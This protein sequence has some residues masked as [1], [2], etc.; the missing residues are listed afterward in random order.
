MELV[1]GHPEGI[2]L[3]TLTQTVA[4]KFGA[5]ARFLTCSAAGMTFSE[6]LTFLVERDKI[7]LRDSL[8]FPGGA[9]ACDHD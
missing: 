6:L 7:Q 5:G 8:L 9:P 3:V 4:D 2:S 1:A